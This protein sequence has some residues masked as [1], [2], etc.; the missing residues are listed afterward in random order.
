MVRTGTGGLLG[1]VS[2]VTQRRRHPHPVS[3]GGDTRSLA[4]WNSQNTKTG[5][6]FYAIP[7]RLARPLTT[8]NGLP[9]G[10][11]VGQFGSD[12]GGAFWVL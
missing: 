1:S 12:K 7:R 8:P 9:E 6:E 2:P 11:G 3:V 5:G 4:A 10:R